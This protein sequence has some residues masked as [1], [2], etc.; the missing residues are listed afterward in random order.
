MPDLELILFFTKSNLATITTT[1][2]PKLREGWRSGTHPL[3]LTH[4]IFENAVAF[5]SLVVVAITLYINTPDAIFFSTLFNAFQKK[6]L[7]PAYPAISFLSRTSS[8][9]TVKT[10]I[11]TAASTDSQYTILVLSANGFGKFP[12]RPRLS[13]SGVGVKVGVTVNVGV[14]VDVIVEVE[15]S[16]LVQ[17][18][19]YVGV[20]V[21]VGEDVLV[22]VIVH[23]DVS[24]A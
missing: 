2:Q 9:E 1:C 21:A 24:V 17:V 20:I 23:V 22:M 18:A 8:P 3:Y 14:Q 19:V 11:S 4:P 16:V 15:V 5:S 6:L 7:Y 10:L 12:F 13:G